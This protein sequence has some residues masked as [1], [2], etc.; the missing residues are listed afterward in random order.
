MKEYKQY[1]KGTKKAINKQVDGEINV[2][3]LLNKANNYYLNNNYSEA[4]EV[5]ETIISVSPNLQE[6]YLILSQIYED[7]QNEEKSLFFLMLAAQSSGGDKNIWIKCCNLNKKLKNYRQ[8]EYCITRALKLDKKN[9]YI[10]YERGALNEELGDIFKAIKIYTILLKLY[11]N[12]DIL[13]HIL[14]LCE[15]T[16]SYDKAINI[17][18]DFYDTLPS[19]NKIESIVFLYGFYIKHKKYK[20][21]YL[22]YK[23]K[24]SQSKDPYI[25]EMISNNSL[26]KLKKLFCFLYLSIN[27]S[28][29]IN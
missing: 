1:C 22:F 20:N 8:A 11:P 29:Y 16:Q 17:F 6:P 5:L 27:I 2:Q 26:F 21:G 15:R 28:N 25:I 18:E 19:K 14:M 3:N 9:L 4:K 24:I 13:L 12:Y 23:N 10:L 7:E